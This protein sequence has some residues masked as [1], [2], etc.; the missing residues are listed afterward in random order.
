MIKIMQFDMNRMEDKVEYEI[1]QQARGYKTTLEEAI[2]LISH[3]PGSEKEAI[4]R[5]IDQRATS[6]NLTRVRG[7]IKKKLD[8]FDQAN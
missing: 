4:L 5:K 3:L 8:G 1:A 2:N 7:L 6:R